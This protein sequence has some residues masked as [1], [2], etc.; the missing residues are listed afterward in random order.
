MTTFATSRYRNARR[1][2]RSSIGHSAARSN[3]Q[4]RPLRKGLS[5]TNAPP[6]SHY[7][8]LNHCIDVDQATG[9]IRHELNAAPAVSKSP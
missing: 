7:D 5:P 1:P 8:L 9:S 4:L 2:C 6:F 3:R